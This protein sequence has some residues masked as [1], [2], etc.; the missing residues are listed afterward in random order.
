MDV[1]WTITEVGDGSSPLLLHVPHAATL[2]PEAER[3][4]L[5]LDDAALEAELGNLTD[6]F[7]D[8]LVLDALT[9]SGVSARV[10]MNNL[11][12][13]VIDPERFPDDREPMEAIGMGPVYR[14]TSDLRPLRRADPAERER[15]LDTYFF[16]Y[17][18]AFTEVVD[19]TLADFGGVTILD[20]HSFPSLPL[21]YELDQA[22]LRPGICVGTDPY[23]TP[24]ELI[25]AAF[26]VFSDVP[27]GVAENSPFQGTYVPLRHWG[28]TPTVR[29]MMVEIRRDLY[30]HEPGGP[31]H[32]GYGEVVE[33]LGQLFSA[34]AD[35]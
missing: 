34:L 33:R 2:I 22:A 16:P 23:H 25:E 6:W 3:S 28:K 21:P 4:D 29:S 12:R 14:V 18:R 13:L 17:G 20:T 32:D 1:S 26:K 27:G 10:F 9:T 24:P 35:Q 19:E 5:L 8:Q 15:L 11:S 30:Q 31:V 7:T